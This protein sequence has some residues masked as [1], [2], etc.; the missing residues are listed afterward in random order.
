MQYAGVLM[1]AEYMTK[2]LEIANNPLQCTGCGA[3]AQVCPSGAIKMDADSEGF[4]YPAIDGVRC[5]DCGLCRKI[6][7]VNNTGSIEISSDISLIM[8][9]KS[10]F[11]CR[12]MDEETRERSSSGGVFTLLAKQVLSEGGAVFGAVFDESFRIRHAYIESISGLD[13]LRRS[14]YV[15]S[16][17]AETF[18]EAE[19]FLMD[20]R[21]VLYCGTPCQIAGLKAYLRK[22]YDGLL[23]CDLACSGVPSPKVWQMYLDCLRKE[24]KSEIASISFRDK[25]SGWSRYNMDIRFADGSSYTVMAKKETFFIGFGKNIFN[26]KCCF[27]CK[28]RIQN[29]KAD[30]TLAD[31]WGIEKLRDND[32]SDDRGVSLAITHTYAG[33]A[34]IDAIK[35]QM[36]I[37]TADSEIALAGNPRLLSSCSEPAGRAAFFK[38]MDSG[39]TFEMLRKKYMDN[40]SFKYRL[41]CLIKGLLPAGSIDRLR[42]MLAGKRHA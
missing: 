38:D 21:K 14:K 30:I 39:S 1:I 3:C 2:N 25:K 31:F 12:A 28:F 17:T 34:A 4:A 6:C 42:A 37:K 35:S 10:F 26:R 22:E 9:N 19:K 18:K 20:G 7:P 41:K 29:T 36:L 24:Y 16:D 33:N 23:T 5:S 27:D 11:G 40:T 8:C 32:F 15:Q 13:G